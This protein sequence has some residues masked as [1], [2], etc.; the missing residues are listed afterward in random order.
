MGSKTGLQ[1]TAG[2]SRLT[3]P[4]TPPPCPGDTPPPSFHN[5]HPPHCRCSSR[6]IQDLACSTRQAAIQPDTHRVLLQPPWFQCSGS[7][8]RSS[9][10]IKAGPGD[11]RGCWSRD[12]HLHLMKYCKFEART[13]GYNHTV[14]P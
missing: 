5:P 3:V 7:S 4:I 14:V 8:S 11:C 13:Y 9:N 6:W 2:I 10:A 12:L 1:H